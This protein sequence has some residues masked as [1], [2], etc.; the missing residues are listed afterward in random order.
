M[1]GFYY[2]EN[3]QRY[4]ASLSFDS[5]EEAVAYFRDMRAMWREIKRGPDDKA[6]FLGKDKAAFL[7]PLTGEIVVVR[8]IEV[9]A[10]SDDPTQPLRA[11]LDAA[12]A[13]QADIDA[14]GAGKPEPVQQLPVPA[15]VLAII[16]RWR[17]VTEERGHYY[18]ASEPTISIGRMMLDEVAQIDAWLASQEPPAGS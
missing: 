9:P 6:A 12:K 2:P 17:G 5:V 18:A 4:L 16:R 14:L 1:Y 8:E 13:I 7:N 10:V 15:D 3:N 11:A